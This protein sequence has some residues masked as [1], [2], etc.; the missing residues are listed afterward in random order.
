MLQH[1][2]EGGSQ[3]G[4]QALQVCEGSTALSLVSSVPGTSADHRE[5]C[6]AFRLQGKQVPDNQG[7]QLGWGRGGQP[8]SRK[9]FSLSALK[10]SDL[11]PYTGPGGG[12][13]N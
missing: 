5:P 1:Q 3:G 7:C 11:I 12:G 13:N 8:G 2:L 6:E 10:Q 9:Q 4:Q